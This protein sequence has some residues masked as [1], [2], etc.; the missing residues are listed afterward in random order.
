M[1]NGKPDVDPKDVFRRD[2]AGA[3]V[4]AND[5]REQPDTEDADAPAR[6]STAISSGKPIDDAGG[7]GLGQPPGAGDH[8][9]A[10][11]PQSQEKTAADPQDQ[12]GKS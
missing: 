1:Q 11:A 2:G 12:R 6:V 8:G 10:S 9:D 5:R 4:P 7:A 3:A